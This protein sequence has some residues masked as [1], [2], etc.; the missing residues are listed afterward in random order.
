MDFKLTP[1]LD[2]SGNFLYQDISF[3]NGKLETVEGIEEIKNRITINLSVYLG[4]NYTDPTFGTDYHNNVFGLEVT[5]TVMIDELKSRILGTRG[6]TGLKA[7]S[8]TRESGSRI[9]QLTA[10]V[11]TTDGEIDLTTP[12]PT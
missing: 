10:Q 5:D 6:V 9:A 8:L 7:F 11:E 4:E 1:V 12:I 3:A 2:G